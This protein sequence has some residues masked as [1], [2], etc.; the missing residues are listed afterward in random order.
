MKRNRE[1]DGQI[2]IA[3]VKH[4]D[5][6]YLLKAFEQAERAME[7]GSFPIG[8]VIVDRNGDIVGVGRNRIFSECDTTAHAEVDAIRQAGAFM[9]NMETK[10]FSHNNLTLYTTCEPCPMCSCTIMMSFS[11]KRVVWAAN[12]AGMGA[13]R[14]FKEEPLFID[15]FRDIEIEAVPDKDLEHKQ[16]QLMAKFYTSRGYLDTEW[17]LDKV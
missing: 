7:E 15:Q 12:D 6:E 14:K 1:E 10:R 2:M 17:H 8:A 13:M 4:A 5:R 3:D 11:I 9:L 16:R